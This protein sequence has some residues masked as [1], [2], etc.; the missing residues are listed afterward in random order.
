MKV[1]ATQRGFFG[2]ILREP[3]DVFDVSEGVKG[4][5]FMPLADACSEQKAQ[6][7]AGRPP[8]EPKTDEVL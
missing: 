5:W 6:P 4:K 3:G 8:K 7:R 2:G 1:K